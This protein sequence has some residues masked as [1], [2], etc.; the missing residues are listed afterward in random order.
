MSASDQVGEKQH[1]FAIS[2]ATRIPKKIPSC[3]F[4]KTVVALQKDLNSFVLIGLH[5]I[6]LKDYLSDFSVFLRIHDH[7]L[8]NSFAAHPF[9]VSFVF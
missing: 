3:N 6:D 5:E 2:F 1:A 7:N 4:S 9:G 8:C